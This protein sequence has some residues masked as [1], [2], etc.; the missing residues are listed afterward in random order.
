VSA[1]GRRATA[2]RCPARRIGTFTDRV[3]LG[4]GPLGAAGIAASRKFAALCAVN[5]R[6]DRPVPSRES[7]SVCREPAARLRWQAARAA[8]PFMP[9]APHVLAARRRP[10][11]PAARR[12]PP[13]LE[14]PGAGV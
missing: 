2:A 12:R 5:V 6:L 11:V 4:R 10:H 13:A 9:A 1:A 14:W 7:A 8:R 3:G